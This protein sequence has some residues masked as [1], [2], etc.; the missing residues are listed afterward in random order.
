MKS[1][2]IHLTILYWLLNPYLRLSNRTL[3]VVSITKQR[4]CYIAAK[5]L[6]TITLLALVFEF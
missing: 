1:C 5:N 4:G 3:K 6:W 2:D